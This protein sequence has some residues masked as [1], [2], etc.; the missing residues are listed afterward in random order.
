MSRELTPEEA[1]A[2][3]SEGT[4]TGKIAF[5]TRGGAPLVV[6]IWFVLDG[7]G[8]LVFTTGATSAKARAIR[9]DP[10]VSICV[11]DER[12]PYAY[13]R[14]DGAAG[15]SDDPAAMREWAT[16]IAR[17][18]MGADLAEAY[19]RRNSEPGEILVRVRPVRVVSVAGVAD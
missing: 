10:R 12:P 16:R 5:V 11:D 2:F 14:V 19:G 4:R 18:Y 15:V 6:P 17:R 1:R 8:G 3:L 7:E 9:R 13:V